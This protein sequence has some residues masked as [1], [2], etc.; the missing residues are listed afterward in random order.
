MLRRTIR[1]TKTSCVAPLLLV[2]GVASFVGPVARLVARPGPMTGRLA[3]QEEAPPGAGAPAHAAPAGPPAEASPGFDAAALRAELEELRRKAAVP[4]CSVAVLHDG[5]I[6]FAE[7]FGVRRAGGSD[8][9]DAETLFQAAS[10]SKP[11]AA[12][13]ALRLVAR[14]EFGLD[15]EVDDLLAS[16][17]I[18]ES[19]VRNGKAITLRRLLSHTAG[20]SVH[21]FLGYF[22]G[23][24]VPELLDVLEGGAPAN[25]A[26]VLVELE[27]GTKWQ[28][29]GG[30]YC[31][32]QQLLIDATERE[33]AEVARE[34]VLEPLAMAR[35]TYE[36]PLPEAWRANAAAAHLFP[37]R[38]LDG[39]AA[40]HPEQ[41]AAGLWTTPSDLL[42]FGLAMQRAY[43]AKEGALLP[44]EL[45]RAA[46][47][48]AL[49]GAG[50]GIGFQLFGDAG[51]PAFGHGGSN[52]GFKAALF[53]LR[54]REC[55]LAVMTN[56]ES[57]QTLLG[58]ARTRIVEHL[59]WLAPPAAGR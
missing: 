16:F 55:G 30:G 18:P 33:F 23:A 36:Q 48:P 21:G 52:V 28:Y 58:P 9:V 34:L 12:V 13:A 56:G 2:L 19:P 54:D 11:V 27:P 24:E 17:A 8:A 39:E 43:A 5:A 41:A 50:Y 38:V 32:A 22:G 6:V 49:P 20:L 25:S 1:R 44:P 7:G 14:G 35:S 47:E 29:S 26:P 42:R 46:L 57:G 31:V 37:P 4:G 3:P 53:L 51:V 10:I 40:V 59:G 45:A 15:D